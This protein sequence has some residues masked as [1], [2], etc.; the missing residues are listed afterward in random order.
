MT[1]TAPPQPDLARELSA[2]ANQAA[3][4]WLWHVRTQ[5]DG[6]RLGQGR[7]AD[8]ANAKILSRIVSEYGCPGHRLVGPEAA[9]A[10][11]RIALHADDHPSFQLAASRPLR[12]AVE[13]DDAP[14]QQWAHLHDR[15]LLNSGTPQEFGTQYR[16]GAD[17]PEMCLVRDSDGLEARR[18]EVGLPAAATVLRELRERLVT[19][20]DAETAGDTIVLLQSPKEAE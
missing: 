16:V 3:D 10:A 13:A 2:R 1:A 7:H 12:E 20:P 6:I 4:R 14:V 17:G 9:R 5:L 11:W 15:A 18:A 8:Y 19:S